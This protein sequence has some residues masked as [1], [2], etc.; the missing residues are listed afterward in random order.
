MK[1]LPDRPPLP[2]GIARDGR[3]V[4]QGK[5]R[6]HVPSWSAKAGPDAGELEDYNKKQGAGPGSIG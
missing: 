3:P 2:H 6:R 4:A 5:S 1:L